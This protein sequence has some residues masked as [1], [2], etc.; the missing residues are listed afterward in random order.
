[1]PKIKHFVIIIPPCDF[2]QYTRRFHY[3]ALAD[4]VDVTIVPAPISIM[5]I[6]QSLK[7]VNFSTR[8]EN[9]LRIAPHSIGIPEYLYDRIPI[10]ALLQ[11]FLIWIALRK[12]MQ[13]DAVVFLTAF[14]RMSNFLSLLKRHKVIFEL[15]DAF[16]LMDNYTLAKRIEFIQK[17]I[18]VLIKSDVIFCSSINLTQFAQHFNRNV[19]YIP[20]TTKIPQKANFKYRGKKMV[21]GFIGNINDWLDIS[22]IRDLVEAVR[23]AEV[24]FVG[25]INGSR[26]F[27]EDFKSLI[28]SGSIQY[29]PRVHLESIFAQIQDFDVGIIPYRINSFNSYIYPNKLIQYLACGKPIITTQFSPDVMTFSSCIN[30]ADD[31]KSF[32]SYAQKFANGEIRINEDMYN[33]LLDVARHNSAAERAKLRMQHLDSLELL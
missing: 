22:L 25:E 1:M 30:I 26:S 15:T 18:D 3:E 27:N 11:K 12:H 24:R 10:L 16:W 29:I 31:N 8:V 14:C 17:H 21:F 4:Y 19:F 5:R 32:C 9:N 33:L 6:A 20:N 28:K 2:K 7:W 13:D 23:T